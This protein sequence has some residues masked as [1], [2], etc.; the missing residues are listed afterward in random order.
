M[1]TTYELK[2]VRPFGPLKRNDFFG[3]FSM[4]AVGVGVTRLA[5]GG[6]AH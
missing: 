5:L 2:Y 1:I 4:H 6:T 3:E